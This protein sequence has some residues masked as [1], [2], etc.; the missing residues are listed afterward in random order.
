VAAFLMYLAPSLGP[1][2]AGLV[3]YY[4]TLFVM[5]PLS[6]YISNARG[7][8]PS[9]RALTTAFSSFNL[10]LIVGPTVGGSLAETVGLRLVFA[11]SGIVFAL[12][13]VLVLGLGDQPISTDDDGQS[14][15]RVVRQPGMMRFLA[16]V[17]FA[18]TALSLSWHLAPNFLTNE[19]GVGLATLGGL[20]SV[21][22]LGVV[23]INLTLG[24][25]RPKLGFALTHIV[26]GL[27]MVGLWLGQSILWY[28]AGYFLAGGIRTAHALAI[29]QSE[30]LVSR[31]NLGL[32][33]GL[34]ETMYGS[35]MAFGPALAGI[36]YN[37]KPWLPFPVGLGMAA[38][39]VVLSLKLLP[40]DSA[41][42]VAA[43][44][45]TTFPSMRRQ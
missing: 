23:I 11:V 29:A 39:A 26:V 44:V 20:G 16:V 7:S 31:R 45:E 19:R 12:S 43:G 14:A 41:P 21:N 22:A 35:A 25:T 42:P 18:L 15:W 3:I 13:T 6:S 1:F 10:G 30:P 40:G 8:W 28:G 36:L 24:R 17:L 2:V 4:L 9:A 37:V 32:A 27:S 5:S 38:V 33:F 34:V